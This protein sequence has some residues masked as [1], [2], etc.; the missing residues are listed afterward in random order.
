MVMSNSF[1]SITMPVFDYIITCNDNSTMNGDDMVSKTENETVT[2]SI[3]SIT[4]IINF[5][6]ANSPVCDVKN[7]MIIVWNVQ[8]LGDKLKDNDFL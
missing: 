4:N 2:N 7:L 6:S 1:S 8:G 5:S 3:T